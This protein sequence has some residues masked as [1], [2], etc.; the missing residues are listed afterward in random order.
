MADQKK[1]EDKITDITNDKELSEKDLQDVSGGVLRKP[2]TFVST[3]DDCGGKCMG[4]VP[5][6]TGQNIDI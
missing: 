6:A 1:N 2:R 4:S 3:K 5:A